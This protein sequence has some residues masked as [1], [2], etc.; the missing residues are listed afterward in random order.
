MNLWILDEKLAYHYYLAS[1]IPFNQQAIS[2]PSR[3]RAD[4]IIFNGPS[5]FV[6][7]GPPFSSV[8]IIEFKRPLRDDFTDE[9]NPIAQIYRYTE[10]LKSG[11]ATDRSGRPIIIKSETPFYGYLICD[12]TPSLA[13]QAKY[14]ALDPTPDGLGYFG[15]NRGL[16]VYVEIMGFDKLVIDA[17]RRNATHF[18]QLNLPKTS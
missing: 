10:L 7:E 1:D 17:E 4:I 11:K 18:D 15:Y 13:K 12:L 3:E 6:S 2:I 14:A 16:G 8:V 9:E 5:A